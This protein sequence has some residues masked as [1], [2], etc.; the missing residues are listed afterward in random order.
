[1]CYSLLRG[2]AM[3]ACE[4]PILF[5]TLAFLILASC[6]PRY[7]QVQD[8]SNKV[9]TMCFSFVLPSDA[10]WHKLW[11]L[12]G[13]GCKDR[14][15]FV[16]GSDTDIYWI[17]V[18]S[19]ST[20][21]RDKYDNEYLLKKAEEF[22]LA[23]RDKVLGFKGFGIESFDY[24]LDEVEGIKDFTVRLKYGF[25]SIKP[26]TYTTG[27][28]GSANPTTGY[29]ESGLKESENY[30]YEFVEYHVIEGPFKVW[31]AREALFYH[32]IFMHVSVNDESDPELEAKALEFLKNLELKMDWEKDVE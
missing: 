32:V 30:F 17:F 22:I 6:G 19:S 9:E 15:K 4:F 13:A 20:F 7:T 8:P 12:P 5:L 21:W 23:E 16:S 3:R 24:E 14:M 10:E 25:S 27:G 1:M 18:I 29:N 11:K 26:V 2:R 31:P 28:F